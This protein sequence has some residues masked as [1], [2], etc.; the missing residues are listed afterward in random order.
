[1]RAYLAQDHVQELLYK[2]DSIEVFDPASVKDIAKPNIEVVDQATGAATI[3]FAGSDA[4]GNATDMFATG[5]GFLPNGTFVTELPDPVNREV[6]GKWIAV[7]RS[8]S[9]SE[10]DIASGESSPFRLRKM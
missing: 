10:R 3:S 9:V 5:Q 8:V 1:M 4:T 2:L 6:T 7:E